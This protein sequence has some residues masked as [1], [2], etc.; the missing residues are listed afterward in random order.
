MGPPLFFLFGR[1]CT[2]HFLAGSVWLHSC[3][4][5][6]RSM[7]PAQCAGHLLALAAV[8]AALQA[9][10]LKMW[11]LAH[12]QEPQQAGRQQQGSCRLG[13]REGHM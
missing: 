3:K 9:S 4:Q 13:P 10:A 12:L 6:S 2:A 8:A 7:G 1:S 5:A 11:V